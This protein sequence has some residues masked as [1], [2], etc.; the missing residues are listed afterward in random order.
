MSR[1][2]ATLLALGISTGAT[3]CLYGAVRTMQLG[4]AS[5]SPKAPVVQVASR[6]A[7]LA[8]WRRSLE[9]ALAKRPPAL[10]KLPHFAPVPTRPAPPAAAAAT[11]QPHVTYVKPPPVVKYEP[12]PPPA[13]TTTTTTTS[14]GDDGSDDHGGD[15]SGGVDD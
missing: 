14:W 13:T 15:D 6:K 3:A 5:A 2:Y 8:A 9:A 1:I 11:P 10:P 7:K 12:A 4:Q